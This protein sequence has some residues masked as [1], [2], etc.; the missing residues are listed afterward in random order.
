MEFLSEI[1]LKHLV[2]MYPLCTIV[3]NSVVETVMP[4]NHGVPGVQVDILLDFWEVL[5]LPESRARV[6]AIVG[7]HRSA[8]RFGIDSKRFW[9]CSSGTTDQKL[10]HVAKFYLVWQLGV[11][12]GHCVLVES[13]IP[14]PSYPQH[15]ISTESQDSNP[16]IV[17]LKKDAKLVSKDN[18]VAFCHSHPSFLAPLV[19]ETSVVLRQRKTTQWTS[20]G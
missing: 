2:G 5:F 15:P 18:F 14:I 10:P 6:A 9:L 8:T 1:L 11:Q 20:C 3:K 4:Q 7:V 17:L 16:T 19:V 13:D 12:S